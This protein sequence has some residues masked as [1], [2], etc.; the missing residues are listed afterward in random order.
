MKANRQHK[1]SVFTLLFG[2][3]KKLILELY[4][5][6]AG[7]NYGEDTDLEITTLTDVL[8]M[9]WINDISFVIDGKLVV[10]IEHQSTIN[11]NMPLRMLIYIAKIY[12]KICEIKELYRSR[13]MKIPT[14]EF[15]VLYN[16][17]D[18]IPDKQVLK[19]SDMFAER[20]AENLPNLE[21]TVTVYN[22]N[23]GRNPEFAE[24]SETLSGYET[25]VE[26]VYK[27]EKVMN[28]QEAVEKAVKHCIGNGVL[29]KFFKD[30]SVEVMNMLLRE[31]TMEEAQE[32][33][34]ED[35]KLEGKLEGWQELLGFWASGHSLEEARKLFAVK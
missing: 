3:D 19:L 6:I 4:N 20:K 17:R 34:F 35:G 16:G 28:Q 33:W 29:K 12:E 9:D 32:V 23:K 5:A 10:L 21:L 8:F 14:P 22:I 26:Q 25:F 2:Q 31:F 11:P 27:N 18:E 15:V 13:M 24:R 30:H 7:T 1:D